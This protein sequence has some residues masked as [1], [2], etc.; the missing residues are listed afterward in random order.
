VDC[1]NRGRDYQRVGNRRGLFPRLELQKGGYARL[2]R[3]TVIGL[4]HKTGPHTKEVW[5]GKIRLVVQQG[6]DLLWVQVN[7]SAE[8]TKSI[9]ILPVPGRSCEH[10]RKGAHRSSNQPVKADGHSSFK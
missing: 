6:F 7:A 5:T 4:D 9:K 1:I 2:Q 8:Y 3:R 10:G